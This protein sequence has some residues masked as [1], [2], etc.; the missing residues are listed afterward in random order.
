MTIE[1]DGIN[2]DSLDEEH[3]HGFIPN[4]IITSVTVE[5]LDFIF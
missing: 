5:K 1:R 4:E 2:D 3:R